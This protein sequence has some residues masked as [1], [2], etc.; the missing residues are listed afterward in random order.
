MPKAQLWSSQFFRIISILMCILSLVNCQSISSNHEQSKYQA[1]H[2]T[3][4]KPDVQKKNSKKLE[5]DSNPESRELGINVYGLSLHYQSDFYVDNGQRKK[6]NEYNRGGGLQY[7]FSETKWH[8][9][10]TEGGIFEDSF[11][12]T[13]K[14]I[15]VGY[16][17]KFTDS[18]SAGGAM[19]IFD[20][21]SDYESVTPL[22]MISY[23]FK[24]VPFLRNVALNITWL[25][26]VDRR[27]K[28]SALAGYLTFYVKKF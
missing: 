16:R 19:V 6:W 9:F 4:I 20:T 21:K 3:S 5:K 10:F 11:E 2:E 26:D 1:Y 15:A 23:R 22:P 28:D 14:Y 8:L 27:N 13:T 18:F 12:N 17:L 24:T 7:I 25:P